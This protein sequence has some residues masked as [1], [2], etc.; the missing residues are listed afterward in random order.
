MPKDEEGEIVLFLQFEQ[1][2]KDMLD[3]PAVKGN[4]MEF[5]LNVARVLDEPVGQNLTNDPR[6][7]NAAILEKALHITQTQPLREV[8]PFNPL[9]HEQTK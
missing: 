9:D 2:G 4:E 7:F 6:L 5:L 1:L 3:E 8:T